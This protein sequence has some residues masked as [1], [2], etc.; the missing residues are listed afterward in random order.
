MIRNDGYL[1]LEDPD[2]TM[3]ER[4]IPANDSLLYLFPSPKVDARLYEWEVLVRN[5]A[6]DTVFVP[7][8]PNNDESFNLTVSANQVLVTPATLRKHEILIKLQGH[9]V[10][11]HMLLKAEHS[12]LISS[13]VYS[14]E[15]GDTTDFTT[16]DWVLYRWR[17][18]E[19][20]EYIREDTSN[21]SVTKAVDSVT[22]TLAVSTT[23]WI[24]TRLLGSTPGSG[25]GGGGS[26]RYCEKLVGTK[27]GSN[28]IFTTTQKFTRF[29]GAEEIVHWNGVKQTEGAGND[30]TASESGG[31][32]TGYDTIT[33]SVAPFSDENLDICYVPQ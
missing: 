18:D 13:I 16:L 2:I 15:P 19:S 25:G 14:R 8:H 7:A 27:N 4:G 20:R 17:P 30:Y 11:D 33:M 29:T 9:L 1:L 28:T 10:G 22:I 23:S 32:G 31:A 3:E 12:G 5:E 24:S 6:A 21:Y 26:G